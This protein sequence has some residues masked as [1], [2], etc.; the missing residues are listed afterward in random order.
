MGK[1]LILL[2]TVI[3]Q[4]I[5]AHQAVAEGVDS[6]RPASMEIMGVLEILEEYPDLTGD[7]TRLAIIETSEDPNC[8]AFL[9]NFNHQALKNANLGNIHHAK[10]GKA[11]GISSHASM[12]AG[13]L[14]GSDDN[15]QYDELGNFVY[16]GIVPQAE[17]DVYESSWFIK[18]CLWN[19]EAPPVDADVISISWGSNNTDCITDLWH[20]GFDALAERENCVIVAGCGNRSDKYNGICKPS[21]GYNIISVGAAAGV[22]E[23]PESLNYVGPPRETES[24]F[25]PCRD[26]RCKPDVIAPGL[27]AGADGLTNDEYNCDRNSVS[28]SSYAAPQVAGVSAILIDAARKYGLTAADDQRVIK[29]LLLNGAN[30]LAGWRKGG[31]NDQAAVPLDYQQGAGLLDAGNSLRQLTAGRYDADVL[32]NSDEAIDGWDF[33]RISM[34]PNSIKSEKIYYFAQ[35][36]AADSD[37]TATLCWMRHYNRF[38]RPA[39]L[40]VLELELWRVDDGGQLLDLLDAS[41]SKIDNLQHIYYHNAVENHVALLV[42]SVG[43]SP[44]YVSFGLAYSGVNQNWAGDRKIEDLNGDRI[45][46]NKDVIAWIDAWLQYEGDRQIVNN[47]YSPADL[48]QNG[49]VDEKDVSILAEIIHLDNNGDD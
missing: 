44:K 7:L 4:V 19:S 18:S 29:A 22:G 45:V 31:G 40:D 16:R 12:L 6:I 8:Y 34:D 10:I 11:P 32:Q 28:Y 49:V 26:G 38:Y 33:G 24:S 30:K 48:D 47:A 42:R 43:T 13:I 2:L 20:R 36:L 17:L 46:D 25:G 39:K 41:Y 9:P 35:P 14:V 1:R 3:F 37:F 15:G 5:S 27:C 21:S 23:Y